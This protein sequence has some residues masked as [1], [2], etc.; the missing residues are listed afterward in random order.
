M[1]K[2]HRVRKR[3]EEALAYLERWLGKYAEDERILAMKRFP[4][5]GSIST[6]THSLRVVRKAVGI[7]NFFHRKVDWDVL[8]FGALLHDFYLYDFREHCSFK[9]GILHPKKAAENAVTYFGVDR[10][11]EKAIRSHMF[12]IVFWHVPNS[13]EAWIVSLADKLVSIKEFFTRK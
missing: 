7:V 12:P 9:N 4:H 13:R 8:L 1:A 10:S 5:H 11:V 6:Y 2:H 3:K